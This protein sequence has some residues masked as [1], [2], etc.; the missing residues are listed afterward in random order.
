MNSR[1]LWVWAASCTLTGV[2]NAQDIGLSGLCPGAMSIAATGFAPG[3]PLALLSSVGPGVAPMPGGPCAGTLTN[4]S[5]AGLALRAT[6]VADA[7]GAWNLSPTLPAGACEAMVQVVALDACGVMSPAARISDGELGALLDRVWALDTSG[8]WATAGLEL[9]LAPAVD[10]RLISV[11]HV[12]AD[13]LGLRMAPS[14]WADP[15]AQ[16]LCNPTTELTL[17][18]SGLNL[19]YG[20][21]PADLWYERVLYEVEDLLVSATLEADLSGV[22]TL[23]WSVHHDTR[24]Y[25]PLVD[26]GGAPDSICDLLGAFGVGCSMCPDLSGNYC[27]EVA[28]EGVATNEVL[29]GTLVPRTD[30]D[31]AADPGC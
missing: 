24:L 9:L 10:V 27:L 28:I 25:V 15:T 29:G 22:A 4:L 2:A 16:D 6:G 12:G 19:S 8:S 30:G 21:G 20:P 7:A 3:T 26:P 14:Q 13:T 23:G 5:P 11:T 17:D 1:L 31:V 18:R